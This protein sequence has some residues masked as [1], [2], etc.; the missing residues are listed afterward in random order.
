MIPLIYDQVNT[1]EKDSEFLLNLMKQTNGKY[2]A[3]VGCGTGRV[4]KRLAEA[5]YLI[6]A[7]DPNE[8]AIAYAKHHL[9]LPEVNWVVGDSKNLNPESYDFVIM[10]ANV[11]QVFLTEESWMETLRNIYQSLKPD[12]Q[13]VFDTR[14]PTQKVWEAWQQDLTP[15]HATHPETGEHLEIWTDYDGMKDTIFTFYE[16]VKV[17]NTGETLV[18]TKMQL[19]F[20][21]M[22]EILTSLKEVGFSKVQVFGDWEHELADDRSHSLVFHAFKYQR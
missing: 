1:Y 4:T 21:T 14:N 12:G 17:V 11:A 13:L 10:T 9:P 2:V 20:R 8:E 19:K 3:D 6:T 16:T 22:E 5:G 15:D 7:I 18:H